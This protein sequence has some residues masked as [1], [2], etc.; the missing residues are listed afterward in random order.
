MASIDA[1]ALAYQTAK[2]LAPVLTGLAQRL[3]LTQ[4]T[5]LQVRSA[6][7]LITAIQAPAIISPFEV[8]TIGQTFAAATALIATDVAPADAAPAFADAAARA[9]VAAP[10][11]SSPART[12]AGTLARMLAACC[13]AALLGQ[14]F[15]AEAKSDLV[16]QQSAVAARA[17]IGMAMD[18]ATDRIGA[19]A[20]LEVVSLLSE[21]ANTCSAHL[22]TLAADLK[23][24]VQVATPRSAP[25][26]VLAWELYGDPERG[27]ELVDRNRTM[28]PLFM[29]TKVT[30]LAPGA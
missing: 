17:R 3:P 2:A 28:T 25:S 1:L 14:S 11:F 4:A 20:G 5:A 18:G 12:A 6:A 30:A 27:A 9:S 8:A 7:Y 22:A 10:V 21:V 24:L 15:V 29:P 23:P 16:D 13:E 19:A 26:S